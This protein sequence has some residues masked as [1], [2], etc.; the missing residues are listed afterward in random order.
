MSELW[1][2]APLVEKVR[3]YFEA[4]VR[5][6]PPH[7]SFYIPHV[8]QV[9]GVAMDICDFHPEVNRETVQLGVLLHDIGNM[10]GPNDVDH[11]I[12]S[13]QQCILILS[14]LGTTQ[15][16]IAAVAHCVRAHR[17]KEDCMPESKEAQIVA[18]A[19]SAAHILSDVY[20][21][22]VA[23]GDAQGALDKLER[24][25]RDIKQFPVLPEKML[26]EL[27]EIGKNKRMELLQHIH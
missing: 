24:D 4:T 3:Q 19:D 12:N 16:K 26:N 27:Q 15:D 22:F 10:V 9:N 21:D 23:R 18:A 25:L 13:E 7:Q 1:Q 5:N 8:R 17:C 6:S 14:L 2:S 20:D 11:A